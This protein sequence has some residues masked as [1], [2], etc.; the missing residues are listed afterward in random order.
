LTS[1]E[2]YKALVRRWVEALNQQDLASFDNLIAPDYV[3]MNGRGIERAKQSMKMFYQGFTDLHATI[4][5][6]IAEG[7]KVWVRLNVKGTRTGEFGGIS[8]TGKKITIA[9]VDIFR[10]DDG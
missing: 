3:D 9:T 7:D 5:D 1:L 8:Q 4:E 6:L 2:E 10:I